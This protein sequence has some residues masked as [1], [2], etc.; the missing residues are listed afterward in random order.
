MLRQRQLLK[1][2]VQKAL[3]KEEGGERGK[4]EEENRGGRERE[5]REQKGAEKEG[6][7]KAR[8]KAERKDRPSLVPRKSFLLS[9]YG[10]KKSFVT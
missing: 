1:K 2:Q 10:G 6:G 3:Q 5:D 4:G 9:F 7:K 8:R